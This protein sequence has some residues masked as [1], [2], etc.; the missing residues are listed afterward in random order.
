M[1]YISFEE[2]LIFLDA[3]RKVPKISKVALREDDFKGSGRMTLQNLLLPVKKYK[4]RNL[5]RKNI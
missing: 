2:S 1:S 4:S 3:D 5:K